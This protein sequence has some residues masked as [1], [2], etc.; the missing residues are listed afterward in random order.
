MIRVAGEL[1]CSRAHICLREPD[2]SEDKAEC[3]AI[4]SSA[5][6]MVAPWYH[7]GRISVESSIPCTHRGKAL[8]VKR[9]EE[10]ENTK[11]NLKYQDKVEGRRPENFVRSVSMGFSSR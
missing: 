1:D 4:D 7:R 6:A 10:V 9:A 3:E 11:A 2:K 8:I 5:M